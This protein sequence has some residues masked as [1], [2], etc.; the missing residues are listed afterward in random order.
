MASKCFNVSYLK[1]VIVEENT[2]AKAFLTNEQCQ[3]LTQIWNEITYT[4]VLN[5]HATD[6]SKALDGARNVLNSDQAGSRW[7]QDNLA[8]K[9]AGLSIA[10]I[11]AA[12]PSWLPMILRILF[13]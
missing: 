13:P 2:P 7:A 3:F 11:S 6:L 12:L 8:K 10:E 4:L 1:S 9:Y 5:G